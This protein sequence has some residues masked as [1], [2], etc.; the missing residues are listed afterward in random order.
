[1]RLLILICISAWLIAAVCLGTE[2][3]PP[4]SRD[5]QGSPVG[6]NPAL[7]GREGGETIETALPIELPFVDTG[8]TCDNV[9]DHDEVCPYDYSTSPDVV[10]TFTTHNDE[11]MSFDLCG[12]SYDTKLYLYDEQLNLVACNDDFYSGEPCGNYVSFLDMVLIEAGQQYY[13]VVDGYGGDCGE[14]YLTAGCPLPP[15]VGAYCWDGSEHEGEPPLMDGYVDEYNG[16]CDAADPVFQDLYL[17]A[18]ET[19]LRFCGWTGWYTTAAVEHRDSDWFRMTASGDNIHLVAEGPL[20]VDMECDVMYIQDCD[21]ISTLP[22]QVGLCTPG[23]LDIPTTPGEV[24]HLRV[25]PV[26][27]VR[28]ECVQQNELYTLILTG[29][30]PETTP[31]P[32]PTPSGFALLANTPNPFNPRTTITYSLPAASEVTLGIHD[33]A[34]RLVQILIAGEVRNEGM[35]TIGWDGR[36]GQGRQVPSGT[37]FCRLEAGEFVETRS[38]TLLR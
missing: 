24:V 17:P 14:Y 13:L 29:I 12:S 25:R 30:E 21:D 4:A 34:G 6:T 31:V 5:K 16:G 1:M 18:G 33:L 36:D 19:E 26:S 11:Y 23:H 27:L 37:Y 20:F 32:H 10:Y 38:M 9:D 15:C 3:N 7:A 8:N 28:P 2:S 35:H 22:V